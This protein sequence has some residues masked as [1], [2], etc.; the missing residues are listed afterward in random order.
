MLKLL[1]NVSMRLHSE[2][3]KS[4]LLGVCVRVQWYRKSAFEKRAYFQLVKL[5]LASYT[6]K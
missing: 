2:I 1:G 5:I 4:S 3:N 6:M